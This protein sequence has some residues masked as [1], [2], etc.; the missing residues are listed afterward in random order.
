MTADLEPGVIE[1]PKVRIDQWRN[2][3]WSRA[4]HSMVDFEAHY[5]DKDEWHPYSARSDS[6]DPEE[7]G[8]W[9]QIMVAGNIGAYVPPPVLTDE[10]IRAAM[11]NV[12]AR[13]LRLTL[14]RN[15]FSLSS[16]DA[17][18][19]A[20]PTGQQKDEALIEWE[21]AHEFQRI[22]PTLNSIATA[23]GIDQTEVDLMWQQALAA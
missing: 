17:A 9:T 15:G 16:I 14:V 10:E 22:S 6:D 19:A 1:A 18:I 11:P 8:L 13:Q 21:Y 23:L 5:V 7:L 3:V 20:L 12:S 4:D 2:P